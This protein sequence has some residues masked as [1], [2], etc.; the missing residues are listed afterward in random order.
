MA[1]C[2]RYSI[3]LPPGVEAH[4]VSP[5]LEALEESEGTLSVRVRTLLRSLGIP[6]PGQSLLGSLGSTRSSRRRSNA[7]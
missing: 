1:A 4:R 2:A 7:T 6:R 3:T 5:L